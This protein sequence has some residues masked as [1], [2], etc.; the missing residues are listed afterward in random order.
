MSARAQP[1]RGY[2]LRPAPRSARRGGSRIHWDKLGR[3]VLVLVLFVILASYVN[4]VVDFVD[5]WRDSRAERTQL[6]ELRRENA[7]LRSKAASLQGPEAAA[8]AARRIGMVSPGERS[9][10]IK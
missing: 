7:Q 3:V 8:R 2:R 4:P 5:A 10:V 1:A 9:Y 6:Q